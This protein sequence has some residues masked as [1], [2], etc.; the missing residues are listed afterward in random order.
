MI[1]GKVDALDANGNVRV[2]WN[3]AMFK[4]AT[5]DINGYVIV[6]GFTIQSRTDNRGMD[7]PTHVKAI[8]TDGFIFYNSNG[9]TTCG[10]YVAFGKKV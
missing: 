10:T 1:F 6:P 9:Y 2:S 3:Q 5:N 4:S 7:E 8:Y